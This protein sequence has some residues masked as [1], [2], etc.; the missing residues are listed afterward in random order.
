MLMMHLGGQDLVA[1][2]AAAVVKMWT[3]VFW[4]I[5]ARLVASLASLVLRSK[6]SVRKQE[7]ESKYSPTAAPRALKEY[8]R[9]QVEQT[10][11]QIR[12]ER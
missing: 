8:V 1:A 10:R 12:Y 3:F 9:S 2:A 6:S 4:C 5:R 7:P 11:A